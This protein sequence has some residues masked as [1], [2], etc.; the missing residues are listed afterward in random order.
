MPAPEAAALSTRQ[1]LPEYGVATCKLERATWHTESKQS[2]MNQSRV[3][4]RKMCLGRNKKNSSAEWLDSP[5]FSEYA[6]IKIV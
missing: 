3:P 5:F 4:S 6:V 2:Q 1:Q